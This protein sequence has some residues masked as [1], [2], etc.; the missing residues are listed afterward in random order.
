MITYTA[1]EVASVTDPDAR[2]ILIERGL[3]DGGLAP[4][5]P[6]AELHPLKSDPRYLVLGGWGRTPTSIC[7]DVSNGAVACSAF[8]DPAVGAVNTSLRSFVDCLE[9]VDAAAPLSPQNP[10]YGSYEAAADHVRTVISRIDPA[11]MSE[12][13][14]WPE[15]AYD[16][17]NGDYDED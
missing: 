15:I 6:S 12:A 7:L 9:A 2:R 11:A 16:I 8:D 5:R 10:A 14:F 17:A 13:N 4:F 1:G 3:P